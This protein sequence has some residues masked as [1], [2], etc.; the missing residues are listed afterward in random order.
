MKLRLLVLFA[1]QKYVR[2]VISEEKMVDM[3]KVMRSAGSLLSLHSCCDLKFIVVCPI[4]VG[5]YTPWR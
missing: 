3:Q 4:R 5:N 2:P 1:N